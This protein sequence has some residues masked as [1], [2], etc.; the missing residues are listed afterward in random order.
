MTNF[1]AVD[2]SSKYLTVVAN[3]GDKCVVRHLSDCTAKHS[4]I[5]MDEI[6]KALK[7][8]QLSPNECG[9]FCAVTGPG[10]FT[11][12]RI[13][14]S[15]AKGFALATGKKLLGVTT[16][17]EVSYNVLS[18]GEY[19]VAIDALHQSYYVC[20]YSG[21]GQISRPPAY[22]GRE[23]L[24]SYGLPLY[25]FE[26]LDLPNYHKVDISACL[27]PAVCALTGNLSDDIS[28]L[29]VRKSQAEEGRKC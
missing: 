28:P 6:D 9:F 5:L 21:K 1:L 13:G 8:A 14:V 4:V 20:G 25:G 26:D 11:G 7:E 15:A 24:I 12:I 19:L 2:T 22:I 18:E 27:Y 29:Y 3:K 23:E 16:F 17:D 10:S